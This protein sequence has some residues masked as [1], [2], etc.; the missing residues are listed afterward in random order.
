MDTH[1]YIISHPY[2]ILDLMGLRMM[3]YILVPLSDYSLPCERPFESQI[4]FYT[5]AVRVAIQYTNHYNPPFY[6]VR[7]FTT[8]LC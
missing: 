4:A 8:L 1:S 3:Y 6:L 2:G 7:L 5:Q